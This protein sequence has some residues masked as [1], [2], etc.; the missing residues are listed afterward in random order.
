MNR[1][2]L[3]LL[4]I[5]LAAQQT[6]DP[7]FPYGAVYFRK[8]N[9]PEAD[10]ERDH[11]T[12][13]DA[14]MNVFRHW[15]IWSAVEVAPGK[16]DWR[17]YDRIMDLQAKNGIK[18]VLAEM[19]TSAP[20]WLYKAYPDAAMEAHDGTKSVP[21][22][23]GSSATGGVGLCLDHPKVREH[24][25]RFLRA[26]A[27]RYRNH[28][29][30]Y[31]YDLWNE[32]NGWHGA[33]GFMQSASSAH[34]PNEHRSTPAGRL[35]DYNPH[36]QER[37]REWLKR[38]YGSLE[39]LGRA[40]HRYSFA[41]WSNVEAPRTAGPYADW[42]DWIEFREDHAHEQLRWRREVIRSVDKT[43]KMTMHGLAYS[44]EYLPQYSA[45]D[46]RAAAEVEIYGF[47]WIHARKGAQPWKQFHAVDMIRAA[48]RGKPFWHA[49][50]QG[51]PLWM[52]AEV[53]NRPMEDG[54][55]PDEKDIR[56]WQMN[57][58]AGGVSGL[59]FLRWRPLLDGPLFAAFGPFA[60][61]GSHTPRSQMASKIA[62]WANTNPDLWKSRPVK[63]DVAI[64]FV[65]ESERFNYAQ[66][67]NTS[68]YAESARGAYM[69]F[70]DSNIQP[71]WVHIDHISEY[72][73]AYLPYPVMLS[74]KTVAKLKS[75][76]EGGGTLISEGMP[77]Y[78]GD[79]A[80]AG[81][82]QPHQGLDQLFGARETAAEFAPDLFEKLEWQYGGATIGGRFFRQAYE[83]TTGQAR[84]RYSDGSVAAVENSFGKGRTILFGTFPAAS[85]FR[86][87]R[88][89]A[90]DLF[91]TLIGKP[92]LITVSD[93]RITAR[94]HEGAG[95][96]VLWL[97][98]PLRQS[99]SVTATAAGRQFKQTKDLWGGLQAELKGNSITVT[100]P[101]RDA[102]VLKLE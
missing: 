80:R 34:I 71:D 52:Q 38:K 60:M 37:F 76:V 64:V 63:G 58:F 85:Y 70:F 40:W 61:D 84:G 51:G 55:N 2:W 62:K 45:N 101:E 11:K 92:Q 81:T 90:R 75:Y 29:A 97:M 9:P 42:M 50:F 20:E 72:P 19:I 100:L 43:S 82:A 94:L 33:G 39:A 23:S 25:E 65:P 69:A 7:V 88:P 6:S 87:P 79:G 102:A 10:W 86:M 91:R 83:P 36:V 48:S 5:P 68:Y 95:G 32:G 12:A 8:S 3:L 4:G 27:E 46:W 66:Q 56:I 93:T 44:I 26:M 30:M 24:A 73:V 41:E 13:A 53:L 15:V 96:T 74:A 21:S 77:G 35:Y 99:I 31:A 1:F 49:E 16:Y 18:A 59:M 17:D 89:A 47:T 98:N 22:H 57:S 14:G 28:P 54:R 67:G 78:F